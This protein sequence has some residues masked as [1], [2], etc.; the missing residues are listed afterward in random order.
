LPDDLPKL[1]YVVEE[2]GEGERILPHAVAQK[3]EIS[4]SGALIAPTEGSTKPTTVTVTNAGIAA[5]EQY[6]LRM[7]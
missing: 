5:V 4:S 1:G 6:D 7:P 2:I 3:F